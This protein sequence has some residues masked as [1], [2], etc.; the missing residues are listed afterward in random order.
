MDFADIRHDQPCS[1]EQMHV[2]RGINVLQAAARELLHGFGL[3]N[4]TS[5]TLNNMKA[6]RS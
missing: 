3:F 2:I 6:G 4:H 1:L 5:K